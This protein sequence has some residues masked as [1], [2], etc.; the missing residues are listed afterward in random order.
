MELLMNYAMVLLGLAF[1]VIYLNKSNK[2]LDFLTFLYLSMGVT[3]FIGGFSDKEQGTQLISFLILFMAI[4]FVVSYFVS[5]PWVKIFSLISVAGFFFFMGRTVDF[6]D[7]PLVFD[8]KNMLILPFLAVIFPFI[9][10]W[11]AKFL[12]RFFPELELENGIYHIASA[13]LILISLF[14][15]STFGLV[16]TGIT[17]YG[18]EIYLNRNKEHK[19]YHSVLVFSIALLSFLADKSGV[20]MAALL[21]SG[22][23][24]GLLIG[25][26]IGILFSK[27]FLIAHNKYMAKTAIMLLSLACTCLVIFIELFKEHLGGMPGFAGLIIGFLLV[28]KARNE[29]LNLS[30]LAFSFGILILAL[31]KLQPQQTDGMKNSKFDQ[32]DEKGEGENMPEGKDIK[33]IAGDWKIN[34]KAS[35]IDFELG[36]KDTRTKGTFKTVEGEVT[37]ADPAGN[38]F[39]KASVP[40]TGFSTYND[41]RDD[42]LKG[43]EYFDAEKFPVLTFKSEKWSEKSGTYFVEGDFTMKGIQQKVEL[44]L[45]LV[46]SG[47]DERGEYALLSG[48]SSLDRTKHKM[49]SDPKIGDVVDFTFE[50]ELRK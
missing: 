34:A 20:E 37:I 11:K 22:S 38:S 45:R 35:K 19:N 40:I 15:G 18:T 5:N 44:E 6:Q 14:F 41:Y 33:T 21:Q 30:F 7:Y 26:G 29:L 17:L 49:E 13:I 47:K 32:I 31:P 10:E 12:S 42:G 4:H 36:P 27:A 43:E 48:K 39:L 25:T 1:F 3:L 2:Y 8:F 50:L 24:F 16:L 9:V 28:S 23:L 46:D